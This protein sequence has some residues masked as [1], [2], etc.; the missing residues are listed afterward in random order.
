MESYSRFINVKFDVVIKL[1]FFFV[2]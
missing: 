1:S 2:V